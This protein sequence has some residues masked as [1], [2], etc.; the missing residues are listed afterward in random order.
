MSSKLD[1]MGA[2]RSTEHIDG[3]QSSTLTLF[4]TQL[5]PADTRYQRLLDSTLCCRLGCTTFEIACPL[6]RFEGPPAGIGT[7][8]RVASIELP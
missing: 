8:D 6:P 7:R 2:P 1:G 4:P 5:D 3:R